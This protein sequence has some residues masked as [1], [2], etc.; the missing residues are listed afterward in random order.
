MVEAEVTDGGEP[1]PVREAAQALPRVPGYRLEGLLGRGSTGV[2]YRARQVSV[3]R[4]VA[5]K[6]LHKELVGARKAELRLQREARATAKLAHPNIVTAIDM[7]EVDGVWWY[8]MEL[9]DGQ[10]LHKI[11][12]ESHLTEREAL[13]LFIPIVE[14]LQHLSERGIVH[15]D[16]K[17]SNIL[18]DTGGRARLVDLGLAHAE[19]DPQITNHGGT[20]GTP[21]YI[22]PEQARDP[23]SADAQS[24]LWSLGATLYHAV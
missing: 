14:A 21:H 18:V 19:D 9:V 3:D 5:L 23:G 6:I 17:P 15:R 11:L 12:A 24:D 1:Q 20:L 16:I 2:V 7:G 10:P 22:S 8:A 4:V 13:R